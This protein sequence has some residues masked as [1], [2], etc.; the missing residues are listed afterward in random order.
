[1]YYTGLNQP[2]MASSQLLVSTSNMTHR[3]PAGA[4]RITIS[5]TII[6]DEVSLEDDV[7]VTYA[8][9]IPD[10][11]SDVILRRQ[12]LANITVVDDDNSE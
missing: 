7:R 11:P 8:L 9:M 2:T 3:F 1:M 10:R 12:F 4:N 6:D 5:I